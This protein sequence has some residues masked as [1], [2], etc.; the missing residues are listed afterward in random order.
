[1]EN[2]MHQV[3]PKVA[4]PFTMNKSSNSISGTGSEAQNTAPKNVGTNGARY[5]KKMSGNGIVMSTR[6]YKRQTMHHTV[7]MA[8]NLGRSE[9]DISAAAT[10]HSSSFQTKTSDQIPTSTPENGNLHVI[11][12]SHASIEARL[13]E[14]LKYHPDNERALKL[15]QKLKDRKRRKRLAKHKGGPAS[16]FSLSRNVDSLCSATKLDIQALY[17]NLDHSNTSTEG[18][19]RQQHLA[20]FNRKDSIRRVVE[21]VSPVQEMTT[22]GKNLK[23]NQSDRAVPSVPTVLETSPN[24]PNSSSPVDWD[25][26]GKTDRSSLDSLSLSKLDIDSKGDSVRLIQSIE[27]R[28]RHTDERKDDVRRIP[29]ARMS[30]KS[31]YVTRNV[32]EKVVVIP[33][34]VTP[35]DQVAATNRTRQLMA[36]L[37][38]ASATELSDGTLP[39][40]SNLQLSSSIGEKFDSDHDGTVPNS[41]IHSLGWRRRYIFLIVIFSIAGIVALAIGLH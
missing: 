22:P 18:H 37:E 11:S 20:Q 7:D 40:Q 36:D 23:N 35:T 15:A 41:A 17:G 25:E 3:P 26:V 39:V 4:L 12:N 19:R 10:T 29:V 16:R 1:M 28:Y 38:E 9:R 31:K 21:N 13:E 8:G 6:N 24:T 5:S 27:Q 32:N 2:R 30:K 14:I 33:S 34:G